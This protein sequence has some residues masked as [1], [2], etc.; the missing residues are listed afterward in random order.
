MLQSRVVRPRQVTRAVR[1]WNFVS[2]TELN[3]GIGSGHNDRA[4]DICQSGEDGHYVFL[5]V[6]WQGR[7]GSFL[8]TDES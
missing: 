3:E 8:S 1:R 6:A 7:D 5:A 4:I 2:L